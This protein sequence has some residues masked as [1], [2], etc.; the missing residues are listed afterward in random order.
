MNSLNHVAVKSCKVW[1]I[2]RKLHN[3]NPRY[4]LGMNSIKPR[5]SF[6]YVL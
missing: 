2:S 6:K 5:N 1:N 3:K 4:F